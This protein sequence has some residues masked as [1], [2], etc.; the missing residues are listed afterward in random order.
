MCINSIFSCW[1]NAK[2]LDFSDVVLFCDF[3]INNI[4]VFNNPV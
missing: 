2:M 3:Y 4:W 1:N